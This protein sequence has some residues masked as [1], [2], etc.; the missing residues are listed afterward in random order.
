MA[1]A[2]FIFLNDLTKIIRNTAGTHNSPGDSGMHII[3]GMDV[4]INP[5]VASLPQHKHLFGGNGCYAE[6]VD[7]QNGGRPCF[8]VDALPKEYEAI[9]ECSRTRK[10]PNDKYIGIPWDCHENKRYSSQ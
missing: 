1:A 6:S 10:N 4:F 8:G 9:L 2:G 3:H 5:K 7:N